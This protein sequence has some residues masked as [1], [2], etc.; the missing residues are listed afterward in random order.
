MEITKLKSDDR[1]DAMSCESMEVVGPSSSQKFLVSTPWWVSRHNDSVTWDGQCA[2]ISNTT[3]Q[4]SRPDQIEQKADSA[5]VPRRRSVR[6]L[7]KKD[8]YAAWNAMMKTPRFVRRKL[9]SKSEG[10]ASNTAA[11]QNG[12]EEPS[13]APLSSTDSAAETVVWRRF[14]DQVS[15]ITYKA[16]GKRLGDE[17]LHSDFGEFRHYTVEK[18][19]YNMA[20]RYANKEPLDVSIYC[21]CDITG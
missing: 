15:D 10:K 17:N 1:E 20:N 16:D 5:T 12:R 13:I 21:D 4:E 14:M 11:Q 2:F 8:L 19:S 3:K 6:A 9:R 7:R 18:S